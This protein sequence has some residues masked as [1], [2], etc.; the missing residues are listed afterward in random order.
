LALTVS[1]VGGNSDISHSNTVRETWVSPA[2]STKKEAF[3]KPNGQVSTR[4]P[5]NRLIM[6]LRDA[7]VRDMQVMIGQGGC[8]KAIS[9]CQTVVVAYPWNINTPRRRHLHTA[10][11]DPIIS[12]IFTGLV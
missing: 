2:S 5:R 7:D 6:W 4:I 3:S 8:R 1:K 9:L 12:L 11:F 10:E